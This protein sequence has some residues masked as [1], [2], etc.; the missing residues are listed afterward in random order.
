MVF[1]VILRGVGCVLTQ[2][3]SWGGGDPAG[4]MSPNR[5]HFDHEVTAPGICPWGWP[6]CR[7]RQSTLPP[8][9]FQPRAL[10]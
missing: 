10:S 9:V 2:G 8:L 5:G 4:E 3:K 6:R 7:R 1:C